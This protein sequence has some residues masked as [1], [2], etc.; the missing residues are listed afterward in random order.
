MNTKCDRCEKPGHLGNDI[1][2]YEIKNP[3]ET[4]TLPFCWKCFETLKETIGLLAG[5]NLEFGIK[6]A[7]ETTH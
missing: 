1:R 4:K 5:E 2:N 3:T 6:D 7:N